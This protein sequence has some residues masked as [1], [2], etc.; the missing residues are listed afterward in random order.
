[1][2]EKGKER[3]VYSLQ[4][5]GQQMF[6]FLCLSAFESQLAAIEKIE[7]VQQID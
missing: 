4:V 2:I 6:R 5:T 1:M 7:I 3:H